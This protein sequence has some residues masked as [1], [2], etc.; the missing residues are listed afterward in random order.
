VGPWCTLCT[1]PWCTRENLLWRPGASQ[2]LVTGTRASWH[3]VQAWPSLR[4]QLPP[5]GPAGEAGAVP[6]GPSSADGCPASALG[7]PPA[8][9]GAGGVLPLQPPPLRHPYPA[10][11]RQG[12]WAGGAPTEH[13]QLPPAFPPAMGRPPGTQLQPLLAPPSQHSLCRG[14]APPS[15]R[16]TPAPQSASTDTTS[17]RSSTSSTDSP[18]NT[19]SPSSTGR[20]SSTNSASST[21]RSSKAPPGFPGGYPCAGPSPLAPGA[22]GPHPPAR[23]SRERGRVP[24][25]PWLRDF[26]QRLEAEG[27]E[28]QDWSEEGERGEGGRWGKRGEQSRAVRCDRGKRG[29]G[30]VHLEPGLLGL[31]LGRG[32]GE[33]GKGCSL[34]GRCA[35]GDCVGVE[36]EAGDPPGARRSSWKPCT[37]A[38]QPHAPPQYT[39]CH[40][41]LLSPYPLSLYPCPPRSL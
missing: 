8:W 14:A 28:A 18:S 29:A 41:I 12:G 23:A 25:D 21:G 20:S 17:R 3:R 32:Q 34:C 11:V 2:P 7:V 38:R 26:L 24:T 15:L 16:I 35:A 13:T 40:Y 5:A 39:L 30:E 36:A 9:P 27:Q 31:Q 10:G 1:P 22:P 6:S 19:G 37:S 33:E 4:F